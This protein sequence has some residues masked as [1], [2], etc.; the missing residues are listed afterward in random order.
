M[1]IYCFDADRFSSFE[2]AV[3]GKGKLRALSILFEVIVMHRFSTNLIPFLIT[4]LTNKRAHIWDDNQWSF[5][6]RTTPWLYV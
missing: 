6:K 3:K 1:Q 5:S 2:E 4:Y